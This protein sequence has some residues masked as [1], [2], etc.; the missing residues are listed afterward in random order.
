MKTVQLKLTPEEHE[1]AIENCIDE[2]QDIENEY[3]DDNV[4]IRIR[5]KEFSAPQY[6]IETIKEK[7]KGL[8]VQKTIFQYQKIGNSIELTDNHSDELKRIARQNYCRIEGIETKTGM[9]L[10]SIPKALS[11]SSNVSSSIVQNSNE[12]ISSLS[13][14]KI[15]IMNG[16]IE[17][18]LTNQSNTIP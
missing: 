6:L 12:F 1:Y 13:A 14:R 2:L 8:M 4:K 15:S 3:K 5:L 10:Y 7:L 17:I 18:Y 16:S 9:K 11:Q